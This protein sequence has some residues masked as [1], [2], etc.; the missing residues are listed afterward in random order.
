MKLSEFDIS[1][2]PR[3]TMKAQVLSDFLA[4]CTWRSEDEVPSAEDEVPKE[5]KSVWVLHVDGASNATGCGA[6]LMLAEP[7]GHTIEYAL[8]FSFHA[9]NNQAEYEALLAEVWIAK[10]LGVQ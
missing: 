8:R 7:D 4:E 5:T 3:S 1:F 10:N 2:Q 9:S 6:G